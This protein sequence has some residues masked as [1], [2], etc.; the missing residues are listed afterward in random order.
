MDTKPKILIVSGDARLVPEVQA[1]CA[2]AAGGGSVGVRPAFTHAADLR[3]GAEAVRTRRPAIALVEIDDAEI[4]G[5][6][7]RLRAFVDEA[8]AASPETAVVAVFHPSIFGGGDHSESAVLIEAI[9]AGVRD[10]L[11][12]P[13]STADVSQLFDRL[14]R[15]AA[16]GPA[17]A[18]PPARSSRSSPTRAASASRVCRPTPPSRWAC[19][20]RAGCCWVDLSI[21]MGVCGPMLDLD[22]PTTVTD[23]ARQR[24]RL[25]EQL[26]RQLSVPHKS[27]VHLLACPT[28][29]LEASEIDEDLI[30]R[31]L[32]LARRTYD[33]VVVDTFP[34]V[35][36]VMM[37]VIDLSELVY[38]IA[39]S[40]VPVLRGAVKMMELLD[41]L[42]VP[43]DRRRL[44]LNRYSNFAG[45]LRP[46]D[47][48][49]KFKQPVDHVVAY[50]KKLLISANLGVPF[51]MTAGRFSPFAKAMRA[52]VEEIESG[53]AA[54]PVAVAPAVDVDP[55][56]ADLEVPVVSDL[57]AAI[58]HRPPTA[59]PRADGGPVGPRVAAA[60][61]GPAAV[62]RPADVAGQSGCAARRAGGRAG[63]LSVKG[64]LH[65]Q[66]L[67]EINRA[68][69]LGAGEDRLGTY[70]REFVARALEAPDVTL[71]EAERKR[72]ADDLMEETLG[73]GP[74]A[75]L[76][77]DPAVTDVLVNGPHSVYVERYGRLTKSDVQFRD[78]D[79]L[80]RIIQ[81]IAG[82][83]GRR[84]DEGSPMVDARLPDGSRVNAT[85]PPVTIDGPTL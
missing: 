73:V 44:V 10:F 52:I 30:T 75:S 50:E 37:A 18:R 47:V 3:T 46:S 55:A 7:R 13:V 82:G 61:G 69:L 12:R 58:A 1:A 43:K 17:R 40:T 67:D 79:H 34:M 4:D 38:V 23:A 54:T 26:L 45:N 56:D 63:Y 14:T 35:D 11:R 22:P 19:G 80:T 5:G 27:G 85:L 28:D 84:I 48:A 42:A 33:Y 36:A 81:R 60:S 39:E 6:L 76:M 16:A 41:H 49:A 62:V 64:R 68:G 31:V 78:A 32:T 59:R 72:L 51:M 29:A 65:E 20:T 24:D 9:R 21:Q 70:V 66:L 57:H 83:M 8:T 25:D 2:A 77:A 53:R 15:Q 71:N 74:L